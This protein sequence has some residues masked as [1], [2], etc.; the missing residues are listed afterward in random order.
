MLHA[1]LP[2]R[3][4]L[5]A[6]ALVATVAAGCGR[7]D[8]P[9]QPS[10]AVKTDGSLAVA[11][12]AESEAA[13]AAV[14]RATAA[15]H[16]VDKAVAAGYLPPTLG[17]CDASPAGIMGVHSPNPSLIS[18]PGVDPLRPEVLMYLPKENGGYR[19]IGVEYLEPVILQYPDGSR[20]PWFDSAPWPSTHV[21]V[22]PTPSLFGQTFQGPMPGHVPT[23]PWHWDLHVWAWSPNPSGTF[24]LWNP[25]LS[26]PS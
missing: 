15:F 4:V 16:D 6:L 12:Q 21:V 26:C 2:G 19:L 18:T 10:A 11:P 24:A 13:I 20:R 7:S 3:Y 22:N 8:S 14:K 25:A 1:R 17:P 5:P 9:T 23:M